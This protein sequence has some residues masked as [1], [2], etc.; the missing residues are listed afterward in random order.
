MIY[1]HITI[2]MESGEIIHREGYDYTGPVA[3]CKGATDEQKQLASTQADF[4]RTLID[5]ANQAFANNQNILNALNSAW[6]PILQAGPGQYGFTPAED[7]ALRTQATEANATTFANA[8]KSLNNALAARGGG[9]VFIPSGAEAQLEEGLQASAAANQANALNAITQ[10][11][12]NQG[13]KLF[14]TAA[15]VL[16]GVASGY[17]PTGYISGANTAGSNA[18]TTENQIVQENQAASPWG[19]IGGILGAGAVA[20]LGPGG[21]ITK[22]I[23]TNQDKRHDTQQSQT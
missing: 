14:N 10:A 17:N 4:Y 5:H 3:L 16:G 1:T 11:G 18:E 19:I 21:A 13:F 20:A 22:M 12:Y 23:Y 6:E 2:D 15:G 7:A 9:N 8:Q